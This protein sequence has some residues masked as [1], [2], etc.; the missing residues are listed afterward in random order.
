MEPPLENRMPL[1]RSWKTFSQLTKLPIASASTLT[2]A[3]GYLSAGGSFR[4]DMVTMLLGTLL[5]ALGSCALN[6]WQ[7]RRLDAQMD[8]T[9]QRPIPSGR[10]SSNLALGLGLG[11]ASAGALLLLRHGWLAALIGGLALLWYNGVYTPLKRKTPFAVVPGALIGALPPALGWIA[12]G[13][14]PGDPRMWTLCLVFFLWQVPH[15]WLLLLRHD[16][17]YRKAGFPTLS[18]RLAS[19]QTR[20]LLFVWIAAVVASCGLLPAFHVLHAYGAVVLLFLSALWLMAASIHLLRREQTMDRL[21]KL[22]PV[23]NVFAVALI[24]AVSLDP[25]I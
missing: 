10:V 16:R 15:F 9:A 19:V 3:A 4:W 1:A 21:F 20:R 25:F 17:D 14:L 8:R 12:A 13:G 2:A 11:L 6:E 18:G 22:F 7:E 23:I 24:L 5:L